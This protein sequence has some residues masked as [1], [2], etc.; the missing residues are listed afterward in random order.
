MQLSDFL[1]A[2]AAQPFSWDGAHCLSLLG[3]WYL[4]ATGRDPIP[5]FRGRTMTED[6]CAAVLAAAGGLAR[7]VARRCREMGAV[8]VQDPWP[9]CIAVV[10]YQARHFGALRT[11]TGR[12]AIKGHDGLIVTRACRLVA[13]WEPR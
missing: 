3:D 6:D 7:L 8:R 9:G 12:W 1:I 13:A 11:P 10:R 5:E 2:R 4:I